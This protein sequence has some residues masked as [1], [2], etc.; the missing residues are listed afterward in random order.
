MDIKL[1]LL[2]KDGSYRSF[3]VPSEVTVIGRK[4]SCDLQLP[5]GSISR[6]HCQLNHSEGILTVRDLGSRNKTLLNGQPI[7]EALLKAGDI[8]QIGPVS[9]LCQVDGQPEEIAQ[10]A[11]KYAKSRKLAK[12]RKRSDDKPAIPIEQTTKKSKATEAAN[13]ETDDLDAILNDKEL[14]DSGELSD[15]FDAFEK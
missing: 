3:G 14:G 6:R 5:L 11:D 12:M 10:L 7:D 1:I 2:K 13:A 4:K 8:L 9:L 15:D